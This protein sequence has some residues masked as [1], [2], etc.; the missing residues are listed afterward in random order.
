MFIFYLMYRLRRISSVTN[1]VLQAISTEVCI[2]YSGERIFPRAELPLGSKPGWWFL[3]DSKSPP[4][5]LEPSVLVTSPKYGLS[6]F[7]F[8]FLHVTLFPLP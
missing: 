1:V 5:G 4:I 6:L 8:G 3:F 7:S 2:D